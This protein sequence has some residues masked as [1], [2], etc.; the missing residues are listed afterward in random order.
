MSGTEAATERER[1]VI[2]GG[3]IAG[4]ATALA[5]G[6]AGHAVTVVERD[7][8]PIAEDP[9]AAFGIDRPG[10]PQTHALHVF[11]ARLVQVLRDRYPDVLSALEEVG[12]EVERNGDF[13]PLGDGLGNLMTRRSTIEWVL[14]RSLAAD[15][16][17]TLI[18]GR[19]VDGLLGRSAAQLFPAEVTGVVLDDGTELAGTV[20]ACNGRRSDPAAWLAPL[21]VEIPERVVQ[22]E[23][24]YCSRW[25]SVPD[26]SRPA[27]SLQHL[28][29]MTYLMT[30]ADGGTFAVAM[31][32]DPSDKQ[33][34][35]YLY[36]DDAFDRIARVLPAVGDWLQSSGAVAVRPVRPMTGL[37]NRLRTFLDD[38]GFP[39]VL[40][41]HAVGDAHTCTNPVYG[42]GCSLAFV[43]ATLLADAVEAY[44]TN[45]AARAVAYEQACATEIEPWFHSSVRVDE[46]EQAIDDG[47]E[48][49]E[50]AEAF[51]A[52]SRLI[53][54]GL[55]QDTVV[56]TGLA[57]MFNLL[58][59]PEALFADPEFLERQRKAVAA[60][61]EPEA[62]PGR[63]EILAA[64]GLAS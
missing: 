51:A 62:G 57:R 2:V 24:V 49:D 14:R 7:P 37:I 58:E 48:L 1:F 41:F 43:G 15:S 12:V 35:S 63:S 34:R 11:L 54:Q 31:G 22:S 32:A 4:L 17:V 61:P 13:A 45:R 42:R 64:A 25:Y 60:A 59:T 50:D 38:E 19:G 5:L 26:G 21:G 53:S 46:Q 9:E 36:D 27:N 44:P 33:L 47:G 30:P 39:R 55:I 56:V 8:L 6:R 52:S 16:S 20:V 3:S 23:R 18:T 10:A 29:F 28:D 40:G